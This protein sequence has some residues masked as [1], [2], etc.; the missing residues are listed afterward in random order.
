MAARVTVAD[1]P[2]RWISGFR[3]SGGGPPASIARATSRITAWFPAVRWSA[4]IRGVWLAAI[5][6]GSTM[7]S[8]GA[9]GA[10]TL[11]RCCRFAAGAMDAGV[12]WTLV[13]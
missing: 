3:W 12:R 2:V 9:S 10:C 1:A 6:V 4:S 5:G 13:R 8:R 11:P 7:L